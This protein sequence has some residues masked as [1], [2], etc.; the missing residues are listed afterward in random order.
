L[1]FDAA[2]AALR[3]AV[4]PLRPPNAFR[5]PAAVRA[6]VGLRAPPGFALPIFFAV[7]RA[8]RG[9]ALRSRAGAVRG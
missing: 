3:R 5:P 4:P 8:G 9:V 6:S 2:A 7:R 1:G